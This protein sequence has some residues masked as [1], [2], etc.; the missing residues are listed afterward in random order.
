MDIAVDAAVDD[1]ALNL[2]YLALLDRV[3][4]DWYTS[5]TETDDLIRFAAELGLSST[6]VRRPHRAYFDGL[7]SAAWADDQLTDEEWADI[8]KIGGLLEIDAQ[9]ISGAAS[10]PDAAAPTLTTGFR[11]SPGD[12]VVI[13]GETRRDRAEWF[14]ILTERGLIPRTAWRRRPRCSW[15]PTPIRCRGR[16]GKR[17][18]GEF[19]SARR[20]GWRG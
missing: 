14:Q 10:K 1:G 16:R 20:M 17:G 18:R 19:R 13:T 5:A 3:L 8:R 7:V 11:L 2:D 4:L 15:R 9:T 6:A 12:A